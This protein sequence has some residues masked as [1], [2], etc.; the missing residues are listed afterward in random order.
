MKKLSQLSQK[1]K[2]NRFFESNF[3][4]VYI[5]AVIGGL[6]M[7][8]V[9]LVII[10]LL[11]LIFHLSP[12]TSFIIGFIISIFINILFMKQFAKLRGIGYYIQNHYIDFLN[13][14]WEK[15]EN[16]QKT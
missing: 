12:I 6:I 10:F 2:P 13:K 4:A 5:N 9:I 16:E 14:F 1:L 7:L 15:R 3:L 11:N 8:A